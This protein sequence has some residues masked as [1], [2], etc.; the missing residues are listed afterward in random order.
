MTSFTSSVDIRHLRKIAKLTQKELAE[1]AGVSQSLI[2]RIEKGTVDPR[3]STLKKIMNAIATAQEEKKAKDIMHTPVYTIKDTDSIRQ[4][5]EIMKKNNISQMPVLKNGRVIGSIK[6]SNIIQRMAYG[7]ELEK[8]FDDPV[9]TIMDT[10]FV[11]VSESTNI[12]EVIT[13]LHHGQQAVLVVNEGNLVGIITKI[14]L[15]SHAMF[16]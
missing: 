16:E 12:N 3:L 2:A 8:I 14:D 11:S 7:Y 13:L 15:I 1:R 5:V 10:D 4:A 6:E 9:Q